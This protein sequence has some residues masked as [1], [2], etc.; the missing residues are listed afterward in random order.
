MGK[1][2]KDPSRL[3]RTPEH[4]ELRRKK[5]LTPTPAVSTATVET[6][7]FNYFDELD[8]NEPHVQ[9][10]KAFIA[11]GLGSLPMEDSDIVKQI[12]PPG[13]YLYTGASLL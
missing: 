4:Y 10:L 11:E 2:T 7:S 8:H 5:R 6:G 12:A 1:K 13:S 9:L 3:Q